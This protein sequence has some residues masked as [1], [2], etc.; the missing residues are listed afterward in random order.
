MFNGRIKALNSSV[1]SHGDDV[2]V[3]AS[4]SSDGVVKTW[5]MAED[6]SV[7]E[8]GSYDSGNRLLCLTIHDAAIEQLDL[9]SASLKDHD[10]DI[11]SE[12]DGEE[13]DDDDDEWNGIEDV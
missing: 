3:L 2:R 5:T 12:E 6:G 11:S 9:F 10:S 8:N 13:E 7:T 4:A 1:M